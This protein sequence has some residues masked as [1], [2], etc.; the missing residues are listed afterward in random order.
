MTGEPLVHIVGGGRNQ[1]AIVDAAKRLGCAVLVTDMY[2]N[3]PCR[4]EADFFAQV[5]TVD[6]VGTLEVARRFGVEAVVTDQTDVA[7]PT[8]ALVAEEL[9]LPGIGFETSLYFTNKELMRDRLGGCPGFL[10][11]ESHFFLDI[12]EAHEFLDSPPESVV[13]WIV[14]PVNSQGSRGVARLISGRR[15][16][17]LE[18]A[19]VESRQKGVLIE[20]F[21]AGEEYSVESFVLDGVTSNLAVTR[22]S[23]YESNECIDE[24]NT[25]L[26]DVPNN[27][28]KMLYG[29]TDRIVDRLSP[30]FCSMHT[31]YMVKDG[32]AYLM[33]TAARGGG[34]NISGKIIPFLT[35]FDPSRALVQASLS[36]NVDLTFGSY[37]DACAVMRFFCFEPGLVKAIEYDQKVAD[38][39][40]HFELDLT[41]GSQ[42]RS[43]RDARDRPGYF[44]IGGQCR[45]SL[46]DQE[47]SFLRS[48]QIAYE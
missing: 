2:E 1:L 14:K 19:F 43:I 16:D 28:E 6:R 17:Q 10:L 25:Y 9:G 39:M 36:Q 20:E 34:G 8:V 29:A 5:D 46:L 18:R 4:A 41:Q 33:E 26:G 23:H 13:D 32:Q 45:E 48:F 3:P 44:V 7:V 12:R 24:R 42:I 35:D 15:A 30:S 31:E 38:L 21:I 22:K 37:R 11:P 40:I 47:E 27:V